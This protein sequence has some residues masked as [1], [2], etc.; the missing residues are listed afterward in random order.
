MKNRNNKIEVLCNQEEYK[1]IEAKA[2][3]LGLGT[4]SYLRFLGL[5][6]RVSVVKEGEKP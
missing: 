2:K 3:K 4:G 1:K 5:N 6:S